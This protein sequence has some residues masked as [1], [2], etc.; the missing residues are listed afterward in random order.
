MTPQPQEPGVFERIGNWF[1]RQFSSMKTDLEKAGD[2]FNRDTRRT[3]QAAKDA[4]DTVSQI[5]DQR[6]VR[7]REICV[8]APNGAPDCQSA[9][10]RLCRS[11]GYSKGNSIDSTTAE[12]CPADVMIS[13]RTPM[14]GECTTETFISRALC[15]P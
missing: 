1:D 7:G 10:D 13:G 11:Q 12:T 6:T 9:A 4:M 15:V 3:M 8:P 2:S 14:P 5:P